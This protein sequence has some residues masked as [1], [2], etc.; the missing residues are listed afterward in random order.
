MLD[1]NESDDE[2]DIENITN[3]SDT[4]IRADDGSAISFSII[5]NEEIRDQSSNVSV[6][7]ASIHNLSTQNKDETGTSGQDEPNYGLSTQHTFHQSPSSATH[8]TS[9]QST[10]PANQ[11]TINQLPAAAT[12]CTSNQ[13]TAAAATQRTANHSPAAVVTRCTSN[14]LSKST[15]SSTVTLPQNTNK[16]R[17][18]SMIKDKTKKKMVSAS[19]DENNMNVL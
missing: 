8:C 12:Q 1:S 4:E 5:R 16:W 17:Q 14:Q 6:P 9:N 15:T 13:S 11:R 18:I 2:G 19:S 7:E 10:S 3:D